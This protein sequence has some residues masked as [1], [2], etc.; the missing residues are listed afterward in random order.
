MCYVLPNFSTIE[1]IMSI[2]IVGV[3][4]IALLGIYWLRL[5]SSNQYVKLEDAIGV[6][7]ATILSWI[8][9]V[10]AL[11]IKFAKYIH[12]YLNKNHERKKI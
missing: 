12:Y 10:L 11:L 5:R 7:R 2:Y 9:I 3:I 8:V 1:W 6:I 4:T